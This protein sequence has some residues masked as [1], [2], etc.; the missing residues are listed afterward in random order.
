MKNSVYSPKKAIL[1]VTTL[2][3]LFLLFGTTQVSATDTECSITAS[4][5]TITCGTDETITFTI[6]TTGSSYSYND[7]TITAN[8]TSIE[9]RALGNTVYATPHSKGNYRINLSLPNGSEQAVTLIARDEPQSILFT[10]SLAVLGVGEDF[11]L[12]SYLKPTTATSFQ[13]T[14]S[15]SNSSV[16][17]VDNNGCVRAVGTGKATITCKTYNGCTAT[18]SVTV[19]PMAQS[20]KLSRA[21]VTLGLNDSVNPSVIIPSGY[22]AYTKYFYS[23]NSKIATVNKTTGKII[24][25]AKGTTRIYVEL[26]NNV[27]A[28]CTVEVTNAPTSLEFYED[29]IE[30]GV[31]EKTQLDFELSA[32]SSA[33]DVKFTSSNTAVAQVDKYGYVYGMSTGTATITA[34]TYNGIT[35]TCK[36]TIKKMATSVSLQASSVTLGTSETYTLKPTI[37]SGTFAR[38][39]KYETSNS[40]VAIVSSNGTVTA[41]G[42][43]TATIKVKLDNGRHASCKFTVKKLATKVSLNMTNVALGIGESCDLNSSIPSGTAAYYRYFY[44]NNTSIASVTKSNGIVTAKKAGTTTVY[45]KLNNGKT[46]SCTVN[47]LPLPQSAEDFE[48]NYYHLTMF[49]GTTEKIKPIITNGYASYSHTFSSDNTS[50]AT[51]SSDGVVTAK[52]K[53]EVWINVKTKSGVMRRCKVY[54]IGTKTQ[55]QNEILK[56]MNNYRTSAGL[57]SLSLDSNLNSIANT[58]AEEISRTNCFSHIRPDGSRVVELFPNRWSGENIAYG[59]TSASAVAESWYN[60]TS[61]RANILNTHYT[62]MGVSVYMKDG[63]AYWAQVLTS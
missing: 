52:S 30:L 50:I 18:C 16:A 19:R 39:Y 1:F 60:S 36:V 57:S 6:G 20:V 55:V 8:N 12:Y 35:D 5:T 41:K 10:K 26:S 58:R 21:K 28:Y 38:N 31:S 2:L 13:K 63:V 25:K 42:V 4:H 22:A 34:K 49:T 23:E 54:V 56:K 61:H 7:I 45:V 40:S 43:G 53:G 17:T 47:I 3:A 27:R 33:E 29:S 62:K 37:P 44:S 15:S 14:F 46:C 24:G 48:L 51:V 11:T 32:N 9:V 59:Q